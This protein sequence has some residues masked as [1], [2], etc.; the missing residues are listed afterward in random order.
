MQRI[1]GLS[2]V[3][4]YGLGIPQDFIQGI[5]NPHDSFSNKPLGVY[6]QDSWRVRPNLTLNFGVRYDVEF[7]P[8]FAPPDALALAAYN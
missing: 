7:P 2:A 4:A 5:G 3:Q 6:W 1:P 8:Q